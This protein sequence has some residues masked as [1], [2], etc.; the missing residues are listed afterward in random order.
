MGERLTR[1][2]KIDDCV[3][4]GFRLAHPTRAVRSRDIIFEMR[5]TLR[6]VQRRMG[7]YDIGSVIAQEIEAVRDVWRRK[8]A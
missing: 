3:W 8:Y 2:Q 1:E 5:E 7:S 4:L 6:I